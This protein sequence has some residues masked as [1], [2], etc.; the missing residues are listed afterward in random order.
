MVAKIK[1]VLQ[2]LENKLGSVYRRGKS[3]PLCLSGKCA[4][5]SGQAEKRLAGMNIAY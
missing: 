5:Q 3:R 1:G 4:G 2:A